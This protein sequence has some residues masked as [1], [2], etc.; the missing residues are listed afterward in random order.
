MFISV[1]SFAFF[2]RYATGTALSSF[3]MLI[4]SG[5]ITLYTGL[6][7]TVCT[8]CIHR[9]SV[10]NKTKQNKGTVQLAFPSPLSSVCRWNSKPCLW[11]N[12]PPAK[13]Q[14]L[15][16]CTWTN[17]SWHGSCTIISHYL[18]EKCEVFVVP[19]LWCRTKAK[20]KKKTQEN[21]R[22]KM[23]WVRGLDD[24]KAL[25]VIIRGLR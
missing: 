24:L 19:P 6:V 15:F 11:C 2:Q 23:Q 25:S 18:T 9:C 4:F 10:Q 17:Y 1:S 13:F 20:K 7:C 14:H 21:K 16:C 12:R 8:Q 22:E 5:L 3:H